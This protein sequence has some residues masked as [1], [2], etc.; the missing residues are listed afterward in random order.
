M[1]AIMTAYFTAQAY[2][3]PASLIWSMLTDFASWPDWFPN[4]SSVDFVDGQKPSPGAQ[5]LALAD[6]PST[7]TR[8]QIVEWN[9]PTLLVCE[10]VD[11][12]TAASSQIQAAYLQFEILDEPDGC[13]LEVEIGAEGYGMVGDFFVGM[14]LAP[15]ARRMLPKLVDAFTDYVVRR[16]AE[17]A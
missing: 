7:W 4:V 6:D 9:E 13:T 14:T 16:A 17:L 15:N 12:N 5:I 3:A 2:D 8:W 1:L 11:S 10:H